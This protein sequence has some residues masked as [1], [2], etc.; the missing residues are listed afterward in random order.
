VIHNA[1]KKAI[2][3]S[4]AIAAILRITIPP[5]VRSNLNESA[6]NTQAKKTLAGSAR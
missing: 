5:P 2:A 6:T 1:P 4:T 3:R